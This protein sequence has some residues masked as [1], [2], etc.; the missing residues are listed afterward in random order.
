[1]SDI[2]L[3]SSYHVIIILYLNSV[4]TEFQY[5][6]RKC[7][8]AKK[9]QTFLCYPLI[10]FNIYHKTLLRMCMSLGYL[11]PLVRLVFLLPPNK[12]TFY[13][14]CENEIELAS[15][16][17]SAYVLVQFYPW[18]NFLFSFVFYSLSYINI[19]NNNGKSKLNQGLNWTTTYP[20]SANIIDIKRKRL[21]VL[22]TLVPC[23]SYQNWHSRT[24]TNG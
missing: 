12:I 7:H 10:M 19:E 9:K 18:F 2:L 23:N 11:E 8:A 16:I 24:E 15:A 21:K 22:N 1:M 14:P 20:Y 6:N 17:S 3:S 4:L 5:Y 13:Q